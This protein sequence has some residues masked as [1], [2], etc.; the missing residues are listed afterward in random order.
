MSAIEL[1]ITVAEALPLTLTVA[2]PV[3]IGTTTSVTA[4]EADPIFQAWA[5]IYQPQEGAKTNA[6]A[7]TKGQLSITDDYLYVCVLTGAAGAAKW[8]R[9]PLFAII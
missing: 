1:N 2:D 5:A 6:D 7:G 3:E 9:V 4:P 8:K